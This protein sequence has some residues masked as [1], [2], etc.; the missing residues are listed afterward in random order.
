[1]SFYTDGQFTVD[2][3]VV[4]EVSRMKL[5]MLLALVGKA[6]LGLVVIPLLLAFYF[7]K[8]KTL[9]G[10]VFLRW[11]FRNQYFYTLFLS[12]ALGIFLE[13]RTFQSPY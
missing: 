7:D 1:V 8:G 2:I 12:I 4:L 13:V 5:T 3:S 11:T 9:L 6:F 10:S